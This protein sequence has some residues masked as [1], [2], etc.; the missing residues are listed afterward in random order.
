MWTFLTGGKSGKQWVEDYE[1]GHT[2][3]LNRACH[4][5]G[6][7]MIVASVPFFVAAYFVGRFWRIPVTLFTVGWGF[8]FLG[9]LFE[10][11]PP[12]FT[13]DPRFLFV[14]VRWW[15]A[16]LRGRA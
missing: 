2:H 10:G 7:P 11:K 6:I 5:L 4:A 14:G 12:E 8:Q 15:L 16:K 3:P 1:E 13:R 9:H